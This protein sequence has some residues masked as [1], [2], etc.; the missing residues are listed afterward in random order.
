MTSAAS[1][2]RIACF[3]CLLLAGA[4]QAQQEGPPLGPG[5]WIF[6]TYEQP[7]VRV[8][9][10]ADGL[11][12]PFGLEFIPGTITAANPLGDILISERTGKVRLYRNGQ[13]QAEA[14][15]DLKDH[16]SLEQLF[17]IELHP[18]FARNGLVYFTY[19]ETA[20]RPDG[21]QGYWANTA[22]AR[23]H[24]DGQR[25][26]NLETVFEAQAWSGNFG[27]A[28]SR[29][30]FLADGTLLFGVSHRL[31]EEA[32]QRLDSHIGK[33]LRLN[34][35]GSVPADNP[36]IGVEGALPEIYSWGIRSVMDFATHPQ[37]GAIWELENGPQ[38][39]DEVNILQPGA[40]YGW[41]IATYGRDYDGTYFNPLPWVEG[42]ERPVVAWLPSITVA[43]M[44][45]YTGT[46]FPK[47]QGNLFVT[48]MIKGRVPGTGHLERVVF[49]EN[50]EVQREEMLN[51]LRQRI[52]YVVQGPDELLYLL[53]DHSQGALLRVEPL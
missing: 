2:R 47:W 28:S 15:A 12:H 25:L 40:N 9:V 11:D 5:P 7:Y 22:L 21:S 39:G 33:I 23:G 38:G 37:T 52:R 17:D 24:W 6:D 43:G 53:T 30:H 13:L 19:I 32:P 26:D 45:F 35:D 50:G 41:P 1:L 20:P 3:T 44:N 14:V 4:A 16:F 49:N 31:D 8:S 18:D 51:G 46:R 34:D 36:Y 27:G 48:S 42:T 10:V 29:L